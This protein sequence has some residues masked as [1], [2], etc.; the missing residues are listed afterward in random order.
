M[1]GRKENIGNGVVVCKTAHEEGIK[2]ERRRKEGRGKNKDIK[3]ESVFNE[4]GIEEI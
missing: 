3:Y 4:L 1:E 2:T